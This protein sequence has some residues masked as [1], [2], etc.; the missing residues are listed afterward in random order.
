MTAPPDQPRQ[1]WLLLIYRVPQDPPGRRTYVWR[2]LKHLGTVYLQQAVAILPDRPEVRAAL[3]ALATRVREFEGEV[4]LLETVSPGREWE[5]WLLDRFNQ[6]RDAEYLELVENLE[7]FEDEVARESRKGKFTFAELEDVEA[8]WDK[9]ERW[10]ERIRAR[11]FFAAPGGSSAAE[12]LAH[13]RVV[14]ETFT[15]GVYA[16]E[17]VQAEGEGPQARS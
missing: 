6:A 16:H 8:D 12:A 14:L 11:D 10:H 9:L 4:S 5:Q 13:G 15:A 17:H 2:Q 3:E 1:R 7:R